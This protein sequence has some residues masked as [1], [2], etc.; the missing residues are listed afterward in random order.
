[1]AVQIYRL[2]FDK[3]A[4]AAELKAAK[5]ADRGLYIILASL[6]RGTRTELPNPNAAKNLKLYSG[7]L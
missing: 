3:F 5:I 2:L 1:V 4:H 6:V 7:A